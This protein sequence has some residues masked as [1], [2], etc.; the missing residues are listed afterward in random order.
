MRISAFIVIA[1]YRIYTDT[2]RFTLSLLRAGLFFGAARLCTVTT[3]VESCQFQIILFQSVTGF[4][5]SV[6]FF[7]YKVNQVDPVCMVQQVDERILEQLNESI[8]TYVNEESLEVISGSISDVSV[9]DFMLSHGSC[10]TRVDIYCSFKS[11]ESAF[12]FAYE[13]LSIESFNSGFLEF[14]FYDLLAV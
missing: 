11:F 8:V 5:M 10:S 3:S 14:E 12:S 2:Q 1:N 4:V 6:Q 7:G 9:G 13:K